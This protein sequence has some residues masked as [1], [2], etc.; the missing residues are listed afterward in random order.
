MV[1]YGWIFNK[2]LYPPEE[3]NNMYLLSLTLGGTLS[4]ASSTSPPSQD[5]LQ[6]IHMDTNSYSLPQ[7]MSDRYYS[8]PIHFVTRQI[9][10]LLIHLSYTFPCSPNTILAQ[11][12]FHITSI[13]RANVGPTILSQLDVGSTISAQRRFLRQPNVTNVG[14]TS[15]QRWPNVEPT[16]A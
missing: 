10:S 5:P 13:G 12:M 6:Y 15:V 3:N 11:H 16:L 14:P 7:W 9:S 8:P 4:L 2:N 1:V